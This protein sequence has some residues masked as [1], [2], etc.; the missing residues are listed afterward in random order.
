L[1]ITVNPVA[2]NVTPSSTQ[3]IDQAQ[4]LPITA[5]VTNDP[6]NAGVTWG[7]S[8]GGTLSGQ[9]TTAATYNAPASVTAVFT[10]TVTA[11]S[12]TN[13]AKTATLQITVN[14][15]PVITTTSLTAANAGTA[16]SATLAA[17]GGTGSYTWSVTP[18]TLPP[19]LSLSSGGLISGTPTGGGS[20]SFTFKVTDSAGVSATQALTL[21]VNGPLTAL[22][23]TTTTLPAGVIGTAYTQTQ[24][25]ATGG[26]PSYTWAVTSGSLPSG[27]TLS[28]GGVISGTPN[29]T[30]AG[31]STSV[32]T[33][34]DSMTPT[35]AQAN[36]G[37][38]SIVI[39]IATLEITT[40]S[41]PAATAGASYSATVSATGGVTPYTWSLIGQPSWLSINAST[42]ALSGT[43][44]STSGKTPT[45]SV[46]V[47]DNESPT[48]ESVANFTITI[49]A[50]AA[51][52]GT[53]KNSLLAGNYA[54]MLNGWKN[55][56][57]TASSAL[58]SFV[59]DGAGGISGGILDIADQNKSAPQS[60]TFTGTYCVGSNNLASVT[61]D[62]AGGNPGTFEAALDESD[63]NGRIISYDT[64][65]TLG[66]GLL[67]KQTTSAFSTSAITG[68]YAFGMVG[69][70]DS[71]SAGRFAVAGYFYS[72]GNG[73][74]T[75]EN[76]SNDN[77]TVQSEQT[78]TSSDFTVAS[79]GRG[80]L[81]TTSS[82]GNMNMVVYVVSSSELL[83]MAIDTGTPPM[84]MAGQVLLQSGTF[85]DA[86]LDGVSVIELQSL[87]TGNTPATPEATV[88]LFTATGNQTTF[89]VSMDRN[90]GGTLSTQSESGTFSVAS[91]GRVTLSQT[92]GGNAPV[93]Y[94]VGPN[95]AFLVG[96]G[97][98]VD[99]G[100]LTPQTGS[101]FTNT[102]LSGLYLGGSQPPVDWNVSVHAES[103]QADGNGNLT[104]TDYKDSEGEPSAPS[105]TSTTYVV[106]SDGRVVVSVSG[107]EAV[108]LYVISASQFVGMDATSS[109]PKLQDFHQ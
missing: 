34:T 32:V 98:S 31:T 67:R 37:T 87:D 36:S 61:V 16:Y 99:F 58:G 85:T 45:F 5:T 93:F 63:G 97:S 72:A 69:A 7:V 59:A 1:Q 105:S 9:T 46:T 101:N 65:G 76:D 82:N 74:I 25:Q 13:T 108:I 81:T 106:S 90:D 49:N 42:G 107:T 70:D 18:A 6:N 68:S 51:C 95:Q 10:A 38:L 73:A 55:S 17:S 83:M 14:P 8:G 2:V 60:K 91:N 96:Q 29:G 86:S 88:G 48:Q 27:L 103:G 44:P 102:S 21:T 3:S 54:I 64:S 104:F 89:T 39:T 19:G 100:T 79:T 40:T 28:S 77:G 23:V 11:A 75:G 43:A 57:T 33:V 109:N 35:H 94:L 26:V 4:T 66:S 71:G 56:A 12:I 47:K 24:L 20:G 30:S 22:A 80:T 62:I 41:L 15:L 78:F 92:G 52:T 53:L 84:I 50:A